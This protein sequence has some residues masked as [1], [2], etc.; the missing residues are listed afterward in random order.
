MAQQQPTSARVRGQKAVAQQQQDYGV[1]QGSQAASQ[2]YLA[3]T[4]ETSLKQNDEI[5]AKSK[6]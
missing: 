6:R 2:R 4:D 5:Q 1:Q 3:M